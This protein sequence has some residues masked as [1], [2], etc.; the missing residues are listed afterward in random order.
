MGN[1]TRY[2]HL[3]DL[4]VQGTELIFNNEMVMW[5]QVL[6]SFE[7]EDLKK[8]AIVARNRFVMAIKEIGSPEYI[9]AGDVFNSEPREAVTLWILSK[10]EN[11][12]AT[13]ALNSI[14]DDAEWKDRIDIINRTDDLKEVKED[15]PEYLLWEKINAE[16]NEEYFA[17]LKEE[18]DYEEEQLNRLSIEDLKEEYLDCWIDTRGDAEYQA[19]YRIHE[20]YF[21]ARVC[22]SDIPVEGE[23]GP[24]A[25]KD[26]NGHK[27]KIYDDTRDIYDLPD[28]LFQEIRLKLDELAVSVRDVKN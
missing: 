27:E 25:H 14:K 24:D 9:E 26:C 12:L 6:N 28:K 17:R 1:K 19:T 5:L 15:S 7:L 21:A 22:N 20:V 18:T 10:K 11:K 3:S 16:L 4:Y 8:D 23:F 2:K 13:E